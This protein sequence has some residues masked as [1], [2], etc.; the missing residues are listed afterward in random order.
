MRPQERTTECSIR[1]FRA[2][3]GQVSLQVARARNEVQTII[4]I[5]SGKCY[6]DVIRSSKIVFHCSKLNGVPAIS[7][8]GNSNQ[9]F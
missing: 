9:K 6:Y 8:L 7:A 1:G 2:V 3:C 4:T 5:R